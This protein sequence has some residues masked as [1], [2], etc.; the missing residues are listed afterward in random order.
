MRRTPARSMASERMMRL[1]RS[2]AAAAHQRLSPERTEETAP[3]S[4]LRNASHNKAAVTTHLIASFTSRVPI[5]HTQSSAKFCEAG[6]MTVV[7]AACEGN[8][9]RTPHM[10][11]I[12][13]ATQTGRRLLMLGLDA[14]SL[15]FIRDCARKLPVLASLLESGVLREL[16]SPAVHLSASVWPTFSSGKPPGEHGQYF[17]FQWSGQDAR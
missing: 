2:K 7:A 3:R 6:F 16:Q 4:T 9:G 11:H 8:G 17:P 15:P 12:E 1:V 10:S 14:V 13:P 5:M